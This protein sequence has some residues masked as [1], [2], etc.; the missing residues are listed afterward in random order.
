MGARMCRGLPSTCS[1]NAK[2]PFFGSL[3]SS[4]FALFSFVFFFFDQRNVL[5]ARRA[6]SSF[7]S[8]LVALGRPV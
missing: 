6:R 1:Q 2:P 4:I 3:L 8:G 7:R 5:S